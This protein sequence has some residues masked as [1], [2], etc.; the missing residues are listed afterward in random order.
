MVSDISGS[1]KPVMAI[2][3]VLGLAGSAILLCYP[4]VLKLERML[5]RQCRL[6]PADKMGS[7][8]KLTSSDVVNGNELSN[9]V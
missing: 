9:L 7:S 4:L 5:P 6:L 1:F 3:F 8:V 2:C